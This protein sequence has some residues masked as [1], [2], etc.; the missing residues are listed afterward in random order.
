MVKT[1]K[2]VDEVVEKIENT[3]ELIEAA[4]WVVPIVWDVSG[5]DDWYDAHGPFGT[6]DVRANQGGGGGGGQQIPKG[7]LD[8]NA[9]YYGFGGGAQIGS[10]PAGPVPFWPSLHF[11][12]GVQKAGWGVTIAPGQEITPGINAGISY[13]GSYNLGNNT[14]DLPPAVPRPPIFPATETFT[15]NPVIG[16]GG[17]GGITKD[18]V[19]L[20]FGVGMTG[21]GIGIW[22]V[23]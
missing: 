19:F 20:E 23:W 7:Y 11:Y 4:K 13:F 15:F 16:V 22:W 5:A 6:G 18:G 14:M 21:W 17:Q 1:K 9:G 10:G 8:I 12:G 3:P 2:V